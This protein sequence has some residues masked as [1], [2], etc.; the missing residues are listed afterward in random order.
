MSKTM[1]ATNVVTA[2]LTAIV[3]DADIATIDQDADLRD[4]LEL[5]SLD[6]LSF[7]EQLSEHS[8]ARIDEDDYDR[9]RTL[10]SCVHYLTEHG[11][12]AR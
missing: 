6:F 10:R 3:P 12:P 2:A 1:N 9:L 4:A 7:V 5:D 11:C 8:G